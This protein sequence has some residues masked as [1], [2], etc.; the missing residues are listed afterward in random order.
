MLVLFFWDLD[1]EMYVDLGLGFWDCNLDLGFGFWD[2]DLDLAFVLGFGY[3][4][5]FGVWGLGV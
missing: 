1:L 5:G 3:G 2:C 4:Y